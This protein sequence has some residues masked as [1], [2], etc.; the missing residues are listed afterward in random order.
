MFTI[1][2]KELYN[3]IQSKLKGAKRMNN[4]NDFGLIAISLF[5][6]VMVLVIKAT[7]IWNIVTAIVLILIT[8][9]IVANR[10]RRV[11]N[12][13]QFDLSL[14]GGLNHAIENINFE[15]R[16]SKTFLLWFLIPLSI[17]SFMKLAQKDTSIW[18][19]LAIIGAFLLSYFV[20]RLGLQKTLLPKK[21]NLEILKE[22][23][24]ENPQHQ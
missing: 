7:N 4:L 6:S 1:N 14:L 9:F 10:L 3:R 5:T 15:I 18:I 17:P 20:T 22:K 8:V 23:L 24:L 19:W 13:K 16:R 21:R 12:N 11:K 2:E